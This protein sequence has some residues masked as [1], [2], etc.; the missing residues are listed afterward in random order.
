V[1]YSG[2]G[3]TSGAVPAD[4][5][6]YQEGKAVTVS[7]PGN[8]ARVH[9]TFEGWNT[10]A[11]G[12]GT[13]LAPGASL[14]MGTAAVTLYAQWTPKP[15]W[16]VKYL[17]TLHSGGAVPVDSTRYETGDSIRFPENSGKLSRLGYVFAG[18]AT[19]ADG[20]GQRYA[21]GATVPMGT[22]DQQ[23]YARWSLDTV[24]VPG[25]AYQR[26]PSAK[27]MSTVA[28]FRMGR[29]E[30]T[31]TQFA[32]VTGLAAGSTY[33][34]VKN[35]PLDRASWYHALVFCN[36]LSALEELSPVY[37][38]NGS[39][40]PAAWG[41][42]PTTDSPAWNAVKADWSAS[43][44]RLP[45]DAEWQW[46]AQGAKDKDA[47]DFAGADGTNAAADYAWFLD[48]SGK[49]THPVGSLKPNELG[50]YDLCGN[51]AEW[52]WDWYADLKEGTQTNYRG[53]DTGKYRI[54]RGGS[55]NYNAATIRVDYRNSYNQNYRDANI[56]FRAVRK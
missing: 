17:S 43:G 8:L 18:W 38:I 55:W 11:D 48:N 16:G 9:Y 42:I 10:A 24:A 45:T 44:Y 46:A 22:E 3:S 52:C 31:Q 30:I 35:G 20:H 47:K 2:N 19:Q 37:S 39:T 49:T 36:K 40:D 41:K 53:P 6:A 12:S 23:Y 34:E 51:V 7:Q 5:A 4:P 13:K 50:I 26:S 1:S 14:T 15:N 54:L 27:D 25:G 56:G 32:E 33:S 21:A 28:P 29:Y